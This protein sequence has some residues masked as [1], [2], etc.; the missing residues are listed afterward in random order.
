MGLSSLL[1][2]AKELAKVAKDV[3]HEAVADNNTVGHNDSDA[4]PDAEADTDAAEPVPPVLLATADLDKCIATCLSKFNKIVAKC[5]SAGTKFTDADFP[6]TTKP[7][8]CLYKIRHRPSEKFP[9]P[10][11]WKRVSEIS[12]RPQMFVDGVHA[13]DIKQGYLGSC[14]FLG[15]L[16][17]IA[18]H[19]EHLESLIIAHVFEVGIVAL[20]FFKNNKWQSLI[21]DDYIGLKSDNT[22]HFASCNDPDE[23]WVPLLEKAYAK[24]HGSF[25]SIECGFGYQVIMDMTGGAGVLT[26]CAQLGSAESCFAYL[27]SL[28]RKRAVLSAYLWSVESVS[29]ERIDAATAAGIVPGHAYTIL[30]TQETK[31]GHQLI[32][33][34]N[35]WGRHEFTGNWSDNSGM[36]NKG[37]LEELEHTIAE[38]GTFW[39][40]A[41]DFLTYYSCID[42]CR[43]FNSDWV[44]T[45][46][47]G[48]FP[49]TEADARF[50]RLESKAKRDVG[51]SVIVLSQRDRRAELKASLLDVKEA[52]LTL[53]IY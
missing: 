15:A 28:L 36:L 26:E 4:E 20:R 1:K 13:G 6:V 2:D 37:L 23:F 3:Y 44:V 5:R 51:K 18:A 40:S 12:E 46:T 45:T 24:L 48:V 19:K 31:H 22:I 33:L 30:K 53:S 14:Y 35:P 29:Q 43:T 25:E 7:T 11:M 16:A 21:I 10:S 39:M 9:A 47:R 52:S 17:A 27:A 49:T 32:Q 34:R 41:E 8:K 50:L 38:D 42:A